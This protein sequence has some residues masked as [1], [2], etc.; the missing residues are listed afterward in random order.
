MIIS[1]QFKTRALFVLG[2][3]ACIHLFCVLYVVFFSDNRI[4]TLGLIAVFAGLLYESFRTLED[5]LTVLGVFMVA[6]FL[7]IF[8]FLSIGGHYFQSLRDGVQSWPILFVGAYAFCFLAVYRDN[9]KEKLT[10]GITLLQSLSI[11]YWAIDYGFINMHDRFILAM[12]TVAL[13]FS[14]L[15]ILSALTYIHLSRGMRLALSIWSSIVMLAFAADNIFRVFNY[16]AVEDT[17]YLSEGVY[18]WLQYFFLGTSVVHILHNLLLLL[19]FFPSK[20]RKYKETL[21]ENTAMHLRRYSDNQV[22]VG[23]ALLGL[24]Y[25]LVVYSLNY[26]YQILPKHTMIWFVFFS[27]PLILQLIA[28]VLRAKSPNGA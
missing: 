27:F 19:G 9:P 20:H 18:L 22:F 13:A 7:S 26:K 8:P 17:P 21:A 11:I 4:F 5:K 12:L 24:F 28:W 2:A 25:A 1:K 3:V 6:Y 23:H 10:E 16:P 14:A 15:S